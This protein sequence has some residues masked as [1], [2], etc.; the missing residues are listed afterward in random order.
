MNNDIIIH[1]HTTSS[2]NTWQSLSSREYWHFYLGIF[3]LFTTTHELIIDKL[4][5][6]PDRLRQVLQLGKT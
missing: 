5:V 4:E 1:F 3:L 2:S 6:R